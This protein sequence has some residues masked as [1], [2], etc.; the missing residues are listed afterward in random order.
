MTHAQEQMSVYDNEEIKTY[1]QKR[2]RNFNLES[3]A[4]RILIYM[5]RVC[6]SAFAFNTA[7]QT[8]KVTRLPDVNG[9][10]QVGNQELGNGL[11]LPK[12]EGSY[13]P[14]ENKQLLVLPNMFH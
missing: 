7:N 1:N 2:Y 6:S 4:P 13:S 3:K 12:P 14:S 11:D 8:L 5:V 10:Q 9:G